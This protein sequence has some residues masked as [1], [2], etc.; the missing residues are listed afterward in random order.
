MGANVTKFVVAVMNWT[1]PSPIVEFGDDII[2]LE[3][4]VGNA[5]LAIHAA[6]HVVETSSETPPTVHH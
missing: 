3:F 2:N 6:L 4:A 1:R 5:R